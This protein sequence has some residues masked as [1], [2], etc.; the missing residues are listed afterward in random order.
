MITTLM[1][2]IEHNCNARNSSPAGG[3][4]S[5]DFR[6][7]STKCCN[8][9]KGFCNNNKIVK[10][11]KCDCYLPIEWILK[12]VQFANHWE[13]SNYCFQ[14]IEWDESCFELDE[15]RFDLD[16]SCCCSTKTGVKPRN[17]SL[18]R[19][20]NNVCKT[21]VAGVD[22]FFKRDCDWHCNEDEKVI[23]GLALTRKP[24]KNDCFVKN[25]LFTSNADF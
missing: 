2:R 5:F 23:T 4:T 10:G 9:A 11:S 21:S 15:S 19:T 25:C 13:V 24:V 17:S 20:F 8:V 6:S 7:L 16:D 1:L 14:S 18:F 3:K 22:F 12:V